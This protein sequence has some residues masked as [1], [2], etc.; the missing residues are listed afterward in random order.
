MDKGNHYSTHTTLKVTVTVA[1]NGSFPITYFLE[2]M[3][4]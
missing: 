4:E 1:I 2:C 3:N